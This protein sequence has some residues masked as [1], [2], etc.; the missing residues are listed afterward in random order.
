M[1]AEP[2]HDDGF[3]H[4]SPA[5]QQEAW[6]R[7]E[8]A[9]LNPTG[10]RCER[11]WWLSEKALL[12]QR[13]DREP[14]GIYPRIAQRIGLNPKSQADLDLIADTIDSLYNVILDLVLLSKHTCVPEP[15]REM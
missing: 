2:E 8:M 14:F 3:C 4:C 10:V 15:P 12:D 5:A 11:C 1:S 7:S 9:R 6:L 13:F